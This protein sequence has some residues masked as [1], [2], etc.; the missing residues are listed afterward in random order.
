[1]ER[2]SPGVLCKIFQRLHGSS[3]LLHSF[4]WGLI[5]SLTI[6]EEPE[7]P[8][9]AASCPPKL[10]LQKPGQ[11][12]QLSAAGTGLR[13]QTLLFLLSSPLSTRLIPGLCANRFIDTGAM[14][15]ARD[16][17]SPGQRPGKCYE[18]QSYL[19]GFSNDS[20]ATSQKYYDL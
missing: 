4:S 18:V 5:Q 6:R 16:G 17:R 10:C 1:M 3:S 14:A 11:S 2:C 13:V 9:A 19:E 15:L 20:Q 7:R 8:Q 12:L